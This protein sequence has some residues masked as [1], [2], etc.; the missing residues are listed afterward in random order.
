MADAAV[1]V[2]GGADAARV[3]AAVAATGRPVVWVDTSTEESSAHDGS[4]PMD[5][6]SW[7]ERG[8]RPSDPSRAAV[9]AVLGPLRAAPPHSTGLIARGSL[10]ALPVAPWSVAGF[11]ESGSRRTAARSW[12]RARARNGLASVVGGGQEERTYADWVVRRM[13]QPAYDAL[14]ADYAV[15]RWG[16]GGQDLAASLARMAH[17]PGGRVGRVVPTA[18]LGVPSAERLRELR[19]MR[20]SRAVTGLEVSEG[21]VT[22]VHLANATSLPVLGGFYTTAD[23]ATVGGWLGR[24]C[25][26]AARHLAA[27]L[28]SAPAWRVVLSHASGG[29]P[30]EIH[31]ADPAPVWR[32][33]RGPD[34]DQ[35]VASI[36]GSLEPSTPADV[37]DYAVQHGVC[38][39]A[40]TS[41][42]PVRW[43][44]GQPAWGPVDFARLRPV[45]ECWQ[46]LGIRAVGRGGTFAPIDPP[47]VVAHATSLTEER[48]DL[49]EAHRQW[50][51]PPAK[52]D[53]LGARITRFV[54]EAVPA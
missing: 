43:E 28:A 3:A 53:D 41:A 11:F 51:V 7:S 19:V 44:G 26:E 4:L 10:H 32:F 24:A 14:Y 35:V 54:A 5:T 42:E 8:A 6:P 31:V 9:E 37:R 21:K 46:A 40:C 2:G 23:P 52:A 36:T 50:V 39:A 47:A 38:D 49:I 16:R 34:G 20:Q 17:G 48:F 25:P 1:V 22:A 30:A 13:G 33:V 18:S 45:L 12:L 27:G 29:V 15:R